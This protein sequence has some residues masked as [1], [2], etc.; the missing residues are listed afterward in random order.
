MSRNSLVDIETD[1][2]SL[3]KFVNDLLVVIG[4]ISNNNIT[5][6]SVNTA[7]FKTYSYNINDLLNNDNK[8]S[9]LLNILTQINNILNETVAVD[10]DVGLPSRPSSPLSS[11]PSSPTTSYYSAPSYQNLSQ[12]S[13]PSSGSFFGSLFNTPR[14]SQSPSS[15]QSVPPR[16]LTRSPG[17]NSQVSPDQFPQ[18]PET[19]DYMNNVPPVPKYGGIKKVKH[20]GGT[21]LSLSTAGLLPKIYNIDGIAIT[22]DPIAQAGILKDYDNLRQPLSVSSGMQP[23]TS[24]A[25][26]AGLGNNIE[27]T[28]N[29]RL[30]GGRRKNK[31]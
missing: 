4:C 5:N 8:R 28:L 31:K 10:S 27:S 20:R 2:S 12:S 21:E 1:L 18:R 3:Q 22:P 9:E 6:C 14:P 26:T 24:A 16:V 30:V 19:P 17:V 7:T 23:F 29:P 15:I 11:D 25:I 13:T